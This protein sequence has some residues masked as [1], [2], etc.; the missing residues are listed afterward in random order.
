MQE[1]TN[2][3]R[4]WLTGDGGLEPSRV[5]LSIDGGYFDLDLTVGEAEE[6]LTTEYYVYRHHD[7]TE[8]IACEHGYQLP[9]HLT[10][11]IDTVWPTIQFDV[12]PLS[13]RSA[14]GSGGRASAQ[15]RPAS[16]NPMEMVR[17]VFACRTIG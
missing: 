5:H 9:E 4:S 16:T 2:A 6:L 1:T 15:A 13:R 3:V 10:K 17:S 8:H 12:V 11:D 14:Q 7:G